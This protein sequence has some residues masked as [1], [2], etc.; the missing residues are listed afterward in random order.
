MIEQEKKSEKTYYSIGEVARMFSINP[1]MIRF[2]ETEFPQLHPYKNKAGTRYYT[3]DDINT[4][5]SI[6]YLLK[7]KG[8]TIDGAREKLSSN[9]KIVDRNVQIQNSLSKIKDF[10]IDIKNNLD[11]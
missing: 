7:I 2:W 4:I 11:E 3:Q 10:L 6:Y 9:R 1:S 5:K 8:Y